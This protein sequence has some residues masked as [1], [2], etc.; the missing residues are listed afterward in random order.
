MAKF[1]YVQRTFSELSESATAPPPPLTL[2]RIAT[3][4]T[5]DTYVRSVWQPRVVVKIDP[6]VQPPVDNWWDSARVVLSVRFDSTG[7]GGAGSGPYL[8][9]T[10][11]T[12]DLYPR[13]V[14]GDASN[15]EQYVIFEPLYGPLKFTTARKGDGVN[16]P[17]IVAAMWCS[18][19]HG[20][21]PNAGSF[22][23]IKTSIELSATVVWAS[24][25]P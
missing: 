5:S 21:F 11:G 3:R 4:T 18:D 12:E 10:V 25:S 7:T 17:R 8:A 19:H 9:S 15:A 20:V 2:T 13:I 22:F 1:H 14:R 24:D 6:A 16:F 23:S